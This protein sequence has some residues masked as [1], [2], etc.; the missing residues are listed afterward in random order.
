[1]AKIKFEDVVN[2]L[3]EIENY[4]WALKD[5]DITEKQAILGIKYILQEKKR[6]AKWTNKLLINVNK[7]RR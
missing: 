7:G 5:G 6:K 3:W 1:M 2:G 4:I